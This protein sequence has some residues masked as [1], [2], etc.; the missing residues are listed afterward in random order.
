VKKLVT[1]ILL[2][3]CYSNLT[4]QDG[5]DIF[6]SAQVKDRMIKVGGM[7]LTMINIKTGKLYDSKKSL[8]YLPKYGRIEN[9]PSGSYKIYGIT[10]G[11]MS[12]N[13]YGDNKYISDYFGVFNI[14][15]GKT[16]YFGHINAIKDYK[17][18]TLVCRI[19]DDIEIPKRLIKKL[20]KKKMIVNEDEIIKTYPYKEEKLIIKY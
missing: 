1:L 10:I 17:E 20:K 13:C 8:C 11:D 2:V 6:F 7:Y 19:D 14:E 15:E 5:G 18:K 3:I 4:A 16:Y 9:L 12:F